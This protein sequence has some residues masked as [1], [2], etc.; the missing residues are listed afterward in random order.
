MIVISAKE[1]SVS[2]AVRVQPRA[3][4]TEIAG[5]LDGAVKIRLAAP[6]VE[7]EANEE[8]IRFLARLF[9]VARQQVAIISGATSRNKS[10][11]VSG[12]SAQE[13]EKVFREKLKGE[14]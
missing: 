10:V 3:S 11:R 7:G 6:P 4:R 9:G 13:A 1:N 12:V 8:L 14:Q 2:F 5:E